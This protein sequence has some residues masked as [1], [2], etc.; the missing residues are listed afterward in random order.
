VKC[1]R[2]ER[3]A[4]AVCQFCG[5]AVCE[6]HIAT[7]RFVFGYTSLGGVFASTDNGLSVGDA[8]HC[9]LCHPEFRRSI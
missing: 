7:R 2:C 4:R 6:D 9:G 5:R 3:V 1:I 8:V